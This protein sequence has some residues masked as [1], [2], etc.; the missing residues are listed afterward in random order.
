VLTTEER[1][2]REGRR[3]GNVSRSICGWESGLLHPIDKQWECHKAGGRQSV[4]LQATN[5]SRGGVIKQRVARK[6]KW[7]N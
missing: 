4:T 2:L 5:V 7:N 3:F 1:S 6:W